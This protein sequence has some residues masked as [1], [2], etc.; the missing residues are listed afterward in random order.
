MKYL[1]AIAFHVIL[2]QTYT[3][4]LPAPKR[5]SSS[6]FQLMSDTPRKPTV[7]TTYQD[8]QDIKNVYSN[9]IVAKNDVVTAQ[10]V[11]SSDIASSADG[12][13]PSNWNL[14]V[15]YRYIMIRSL[16]EQQTKRRTRH[17]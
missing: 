17:Q 8:I 3:R 2:L 15:F 1:L 12:N 9:A 5:A 14:Q 16:V 7:F 6:G 11:V 13:P 4:A 10:V